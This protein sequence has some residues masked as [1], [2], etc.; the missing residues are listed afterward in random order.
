MYSIQST[1]KGTLLPVFIRILVQ[2]LAENRLSAPFF[3]CAISRGCYEKLVNRI[4]KSVLKSNTKIPNSIQNSVH[5]LEAIIIKIINPIILQPNHN[6]SRLKSDVFPQ[7][8]Q[9]IIDD[10]RHS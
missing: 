3:N 7:W 4:L 6:N 5:H 10:Y 2:C 1:R 9:I 8:N